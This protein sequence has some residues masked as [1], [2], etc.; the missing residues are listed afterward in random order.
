MIGNK[1][2]VD[3][4]ALLRRSTGPSACRPASRWHGCA[5]SVSASR[6]S[7]R[8]SACIRAWRRSWRTAR[9]MIAGEMPLDWGCAE[10][11]AY[12]TLLEDGFSVRLTGQD[13]G[14]GT[15]FH[16]HAVLHDQNTGAICMPLAARRRAA[17]ARADD[18]LGA[19][20]RGRD[21]LR[22]RLR[23]HRAGVA[24]DLGGAVRRL[25]QRGAGHHR[26]VHQLR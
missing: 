17:A 2:T 3:W 26:S 15:F 20:R 1:Y 11:L 4:S 18:R 8:G 24:G 16:R 25:R 7:R 22:V 14:R 12:A 13:S 21:G 9:N 10:T 23:H 5:R 19:L 6:V